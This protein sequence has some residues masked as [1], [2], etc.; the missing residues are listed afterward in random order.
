[1]SEIQPT[2]FCK[3]FESPG[4]LVFMWAEVELEEVSSE[5][6]FLPSVTQL[7]KCVLD[8]SCTL[9]IQIPPEVRFL[10]FF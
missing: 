2:N 5:T 4:F 10:K 1:M 3:R 7:E 8:Y 9:D 6:P